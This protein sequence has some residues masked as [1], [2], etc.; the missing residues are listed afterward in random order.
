[1]NIREFAVAVAVVSLMLGSAG[2]SDGADV[3]PSAHVTA[4]EVAA[5]ATPDA[6]SAHEQAAEHADHDQAAPVLAEGQRWETDAPLRAAMTRIHDAVALNLPAYHQGR[7]QVE[8]ADALAIGVENDIDYMFA[9]CKLSPEP[10]AALHVLIGRMMGALEALKTDPAS[11]EGMPQLVAVVNDY[12]T[13][14]DHEGF[15]PLTHD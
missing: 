14:F 6:T 8:D 4:D 10:D 9:N 2:C 1:M 13:T 5:S 7:L 12:Q 11:S 15:Q 3:D